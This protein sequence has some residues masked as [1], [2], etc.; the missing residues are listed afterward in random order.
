MTGYQIDDK[1]DKDFKSAK[2]A[3][4]EDDLLVLALYM[5]AGPMQGISTEYRLREGG[6][7]DIPEYLDGFIEY[8]WLWDP[9]FE[10]IPFTENGASVADELV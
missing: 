9:D 6:K 3:A 5:E 10:Y 8:K 4:G 7:H 2:P 1:I